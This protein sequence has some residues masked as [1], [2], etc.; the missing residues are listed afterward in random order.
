LGDS[1]VLAQADLEPPLSLRVARA[2]KLAEAPLDG[3]EF[4]RA[5]GP[6]KTPQRTEDRPGRKAHFGKLLLCVERATF[7]YEAAGD[8]G[9]SETIR[10]LDDVSLEIHEREVHA[11]I[12]TDGAGK[13]TLARLMAGL[14]KPQ[15]G[16]VRVEGTNTRH[17][18]IAQLA[19]QVGITFQNPDEQLSERTIDE[20]VGF[21][22]QQRRRQ[23]DGEF[24]KGERSNEE[25]I[26]ERVDRACE[27]LE[28]DAALRQSDP[29]LLPR[30]LRKMVVMAEALV[31]DPSVLVLDEPSGGLDTRLR[32]KLKRLLGRLREQNKGI[33]LIDHDIDLV[34]AVA[35]TVT[36]LDKGKVR[37]EG[38]CVPC[39]GRQARPRLPTCTSGPRMQRNWPAAS[40]WTPSWV[41][42]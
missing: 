4:A 23:K 11:L 1:A 19:H 10:A 16:Q 7:C 32:Q 29:S 17:R 42:S 14:S 18:K 8:A 30:G 25:F 35:D 38:R 22:L 34:C 41:T 13:T 36:V 40:A 28:L 24:P 9:E 20:E 3:D 6:V 2:L 37:C 26:R 27:L 15:E 21:P 33:L 5:L 31:L 12:G 39:L